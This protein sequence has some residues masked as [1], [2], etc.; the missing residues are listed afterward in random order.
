[1][2]GVLVVILKSSILDEL[3][4]E[5]AIVGVVDLLGHQ[6]VE[7]GADRRGHLRGIDM[8]RR[9]GPQPG[10]RGEAKKERGDTDDG[11]GG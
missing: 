1:M 4:I 9:I 3:G 10:I 8:E 11:A 6:A 7:H 5:P 2:N